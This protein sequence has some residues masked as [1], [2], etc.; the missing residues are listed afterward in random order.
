MERIPPRVVAV[1]T[2]APPGKGAAP[3][4]NST[5]LDQWRGFALLLV[6]ISHGFYFT[7]RV[8]GIGRVGV[9]LFFF[10]SGV[11]VFRSL[12]RSRETGLALA[13]GF[14]KRRLRRLYP[15]LGAYVLAMAPIVYALRNVPGAVDAGPAGFWRGVPWALTYVMNYSRSMPMSLGHLWSLSC[16]MQFYLL[17]P[18]IFLLGGTTVFRRHLVWGALLL[19]LAGAGL[20]GPLL[21]MP[22]AWKYDFEFAVWPMMLGFCCEYRR[23]LFLRVPG[24]WFTPILWGSAAI[25]CVLGALMLGGLEMKKPVIAIGTYAFLPCF[26]AYVAR[27]PLAGTLGQVFTW[28]GERTYSIYLWQQPLTICHYLPT[29]WHPFGSAAS[30]L[31][32]GL[33]FRWFERPFL[34]A[35]RQDVVR[36]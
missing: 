25:F 32:G 30:T 4:G 28:L 6:L 23:D 26:L 11:L 17:A 15:A 3:G 20:G 12:S 34:S 18:A 22:D 5:A 2:P 24:S 8:H 7:G 9:N 13:A 27:R 1:E 21:H 31:V 16:E 10:I 35:G 19:A 14:W 36:R 33:W 29:F